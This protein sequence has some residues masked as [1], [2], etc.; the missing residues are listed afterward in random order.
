MAA[1]KEVPQNTEAKPVYAPGAKWERIE[2][3]ADK[4]ELECTYAIDLLDDAKKVIGVRTTQDIYTEA[5]CKALHKKMKEERQQFELRTK[6]LKQ[7]IGNIKIDEEMEED[8]KLLEQQLMKIQHRQQNKGNIEGYKNSQEA[9]HH[10][11]RQIAT[12][13]GKVPILKRQK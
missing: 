4:R 9:L 11:N 3:H 7:A 2:F 6:Q 12:I 5:G 10:L 1:K 13:E 8:I